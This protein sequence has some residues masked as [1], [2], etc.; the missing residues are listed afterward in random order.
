VSHEPEP[1]A[2]HP[3]KGKESRRRFDNRNRVTDI[4]LARPAWDV[5][6]IISPLMRQFSR[7]RGYRVGDVD[8]G[9][10][11]AKHQGTVHQSKNVRRWRE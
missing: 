3:V 9:C 6:A 1:S 10:G 11:R 5:P 8:A 4:P 2:G 7:E